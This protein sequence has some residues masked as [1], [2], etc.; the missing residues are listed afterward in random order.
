MHPQTDCPFLTKLSFKLRVQIYELVLGNCLIRTAVDITDRSRDFDP[1]TAFWQAASSTAHLIEWSR[2]SLRGHHMLSEGICQPIQASGKRTLITV[3]LL[4]T[5]RLMHNECVQLLYASNAF[6][7]RCLQDFEEFS[8]RYLDDDG[9]GGEKRITWVKKLQINSGNMVFKV[10]KVVFGA[11]SLQLLSIGTD[12]DTFLLPGLYAPH[13]D[14]LRVLLKLSDLPNLTQI[15]I[16]WTTWPPWYLS[17]SCTKRWAHRQSDKEAKASSSAISKPLT[18]VASYPGTRPD[19]CRQHC[20]GGLTLVQWVQVEVMKSMKNQGYPCE[21]QGLYWAGVGLSLVA[22]TETGDGTLEGDEGDDISTD[23]ASD[24]D[25]ASSEER[26]FYRNFV[27]PAKELYLE[28]NE[29]QAEKEEEYEN[30]YG[31]SLEFTS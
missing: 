29:L 22:G 5:C 15:E 19:F 11:S 16:F 7:F 26:E 8:S 10:P 2:R 28:V 9:N 27:S 23:E 30:V 1:F 18:T 17:E 4:L 25:N 21:L 20:K 24:W 12:P 3:A 14:A 6:S 31:E 13:R